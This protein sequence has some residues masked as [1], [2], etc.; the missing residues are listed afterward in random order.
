MKVRYSGGG[1]FGAAPWKGMKISCATSSRSVMPASQR[2]TAGEVF[3]P[4]A[5][6]AGAVTRRAAGAQRA[7]TENSRRSAVQLGNTGTLS[8]VADFNY[9]QRESAAAG[10][11]A[12][13]GP[14]ARRDLP[15][16]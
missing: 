6:R 11:V 10:S 1:E 9:R 8:S 4:E 3:R 16:V 2:R 14:C 5:G 7:G 12:N 15:A 13:P